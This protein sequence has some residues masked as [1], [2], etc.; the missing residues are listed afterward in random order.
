MDKLSLKI[1]LIQK[2]IHTH[3]HKKLSLKFIVIIPFF[4]LKL[5]NKINSKRKK[6]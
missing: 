2:V 3:T 5:K 4:L 6:N 1:D